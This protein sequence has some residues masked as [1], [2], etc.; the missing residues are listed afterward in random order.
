LVIDSRCFYFDGG[1]VRRELHLSLFLLFGLVCPAQTQDQKSDSISS[2][3][4]IVEEL[5][6]GGFLFQSIS[7]QAFGSDENS[8]ISNP[9]FY[10]VSIIKIYN[11]KILNCVIT[12]N[13]FRLAIAREN[14]TQYTPIEQVNKAIEKTSNS[15]DATHL[16]DFDESSHNLF[17]YD[18]IEAGMKT[19]EY[20]LWDYNIANHQL[21]SIC[22]CSFV[23]KCFPSP[24]GKYLAILDND[25]P[26]FAIFDLTQTSATAKNL[27]TKYSAK[28]FNK[29]DYLPN[30]KVEDKWIGW[31]PGDV[32]MATHII[33]KGI[34]ESQESMDN[35]TRESVPAKREEAVIASPADF[36]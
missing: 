20:L 13:D 19:P 36:Q 35:S 14:N 30:L 21:K 16:L 15:N 34:S 17:L 2:N 3:E 4:G 8:N 24:S 7:P 18:E 9:P 27:W 23:G 25:Y 26:E 33:S 29:N 32:I 31:L 1:S 11:N 10:N 6:K 12:C 5:N 22:Y 28:H